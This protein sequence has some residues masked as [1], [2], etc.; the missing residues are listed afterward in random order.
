MTSPMFDNLSCAS[1]N[2]SSA[3]PFTLNQSPQ[4]LRADHDEA[5]LPDCSNA[6]TSQRAKLMVILDLSGSNESISAI[7]F[8]HIL[9]DGLIFVAYVKL[10]Q[11]QLKPRSA[12]LS[13]LSSEK[14]LLPGPA[15][16]PIVSS[17]FRRSVSGRVRQTSC[18]DAHHDL[19]GD[20]MPREE[21][22]LRR[23]IDSAMLDAHID[24]KVEQK[25]RHCDLPTVYLSSSFTREQRKALRKLKK[26]IADAEQDERE[27]N[28]LELPAEKYHDLVS[29]KRLELERLTALFESVNRRPVSSSFKMMEINE[30]KTKSTTCTTSFEGDDEANTINSTLPSACLPP[31]PQEC[32]S[33]SRFSHWSWSSQNDS[34][35][36]DINHF[37][38]LGNRKI[39]A[40]FLPDNGSMA[41]GRRR[42]TRSD[43]IDCDRKRDDGFSSFMSFRRRHYPEKNHPQGKNSMQ[44]VSS[45]K[46]NE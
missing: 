15:G 27:A 35:T 13:V 1:Y 46:I 5:G 30:D 10:S 24:M 2:P 40:P 31:S 12:S 45:V 19:F 33:P 42:T 20:A 17:P 11:M 39:V 36:M 6:N 37:N 8:T 32:K 44:Q 38:G 14:G 34:P 28:E 21:N 43:K 16:S 7:L 3:A 18:R 4:P 25:S 23:G 26:E 9:L 29:D 41:C 22:L